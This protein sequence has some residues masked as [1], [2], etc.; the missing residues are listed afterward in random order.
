MVVVQVPLEIADAQFVRCLKFAVVFVVLLNCIVGQMDHPVHISQ[1][2]LITRGTEVAI[3]VHV[4]LQQAIDAGKHGK[5][6]HVELPIG[7]QQRLVNVQLYYACA[8]AVGP[9]VGIDQLLDFTQCVSDFNSAT[10]VR[11]LTGL[12]DPYI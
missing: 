6:P 2:K 5:C 3:A 12:D 11:I 7:Y 8:V 1:I 4:A 9:S 10:T